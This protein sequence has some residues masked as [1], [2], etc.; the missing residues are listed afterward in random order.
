[1][2]DDLTDCFRVDLMAWGQQH[3]R[4]FPWRDPDIS[5]YEMLMAEFF[6]ARTRAP[7]V[8]R[9]FPEF[10]EEFPNL[11]TL[12]EADESR[13]AEVIR[14]TGL[15]NRRAAALKELAASLE[16]RSVPD[17]AEELMELPRVGRY[18][19]NATL[20][21]GH[22]APLPILDT[23]VERVFGRLLGD[24][25]PPHEEAQLELLSEVLPDD[26]ARQFN[27]FLLDF[28]SEV[29][30]AQAP[31]CES[32]FAAAYCSYYAATGEESE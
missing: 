11:A 23:N 3:Q 15:Q 2:P 14:P 7:V 12:R 5:L 28:G 29:C 25:W 24:A 13:I 32:C 6:L 9:V 30:S 8:A 19:A 22:G 4:D 16:G 21:F 10:I 17:S 20:T 26:E 27:L 18:V 1:M 31:D